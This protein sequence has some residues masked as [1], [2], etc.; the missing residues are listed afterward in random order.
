MYIKADGSI[1]AVG[2]MKSTGNKDLD[3]AA[4]A[5]LYRWHAIPGGPREVDMP[6]TFHMSP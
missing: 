5:G 1:R 3:I 6:V 2:V 4:A